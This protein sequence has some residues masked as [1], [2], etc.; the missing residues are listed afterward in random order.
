MLLAYRKAKYTVFR[1]RSLHQTADFA[2]YELSLSKRLKQLQ[3]ALLGGGDSLFAKLPEGLGTSFQVPKQDAWRSESTGSGRK[4]RVM[5][6]PSVD[7]HVI[8]ALWI[9]TVGHRLDALLSK[10]ALGARLRRDAASKQFVLGSPMVFRSYVHQYRKWRNQ[11]TS[12]LEEQAL[13]EQS[14]ALISLDLADYYRT[15]PASRVTSVEY[16]N[17][18]LASEQ[19]APLSQHEDY[20]TQ[21]LSAAI[22][23]WHAAQPALAKMPAGLPIGLA[24]SRVLGNIVLHDFDR[25]TTSALAPLY[26]SRYI[27]DLLFVLRCSQSDTQE[28]ALNTLVERH[29]HLS[30]SVQHGMVLTCPSIPHNFAV[31]KLKRSI[32]VVREKGDVYHVRNLAATLRQLS[33]ESRLLPDDTPTESTAASRALRSPWDSGADGER[34]ISGDSSTGYRLGFASLLRQAFLRSRDLRPGDWREE[35]EAFFH[36]IRRGLSG[37]EQL[38]TLYDYLP[39]VVA[40]AAAC[41]EWTHARRLVAEALRRVRAKSE[42]EAYRSVEWKSFLSYLARA[43]GDVVVTLPRTDDQ[44]LGLLDHVSRESGVDLSEFSAD[45][46]RV[47]S[48]C[49]AYDLAWIPLKAEILS[50]DFSALAVSG[51]GAVALGKDSGITAWLEAIRKIL[52]RLGLDARLAPQ[53]WLATRPLR[54]VEILERL[55]M[56][57]DL[58]LSGAY[59]LALAASEALWGAEAALAPPSLVKGAEGRPNV[60]VIGEADDA[61]PVVT[62]GV[63]NVL[64][65]VDHWEAAACGAPREDAERY[66][67]LMRL[68]NAFLVARPRP[69]LVVFPELSIPRC[70]VDTIAEA[71]TREGISA[72]LGLEYFSASDGSGGRAV[73]NEAWLYLVGPTPRRS[74]TM[75]KQGK[76]RPALHEGLELK[77]VAGATLR[78]GALPRPIYELNGFRFGLLICSELT[79]ISARSAF[80][81]EVDALLVVSWNR[82]L[83][84]FESIVDATCNDLHSYLVLANNRRYGDSRIRGP[85]RQEWARDVLRVRGGNEDFAICG[86]LHVDRLRREQSYVHVADDSFFKPTPDGFKVSPERRVVPGTKQKDRD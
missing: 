2:R 19:A 4:F 40:L 24:A 21:V 45:L 41:H 11:A 14:A 59:E 22:A 67:R 8:S 55:S 6:F 68:V 66:H 17:A 1:E 64:T 81:G 80:R 84:L 71:L 30:T 25:V 15:V 48:A 28:D 63:A 12:V 82:D 73:V 57:P 38:G 36:T 9:N 20:L 74:V 29:P 54:P 85:M 43:L 65:E 39:R 10:S 7:F 61:R 60:A 47:A 49:R 72:V 77:R 18:L 5:A 53:L 52:R 35:R 46:A 32:H 16:L 58:D 76:V 44:G 69:D 42:T 75:I 3:A 34:L 70:W 26:Y 50:E 86:G 31:N 78:P 62:I 56:S 79:D 27:D 37:E 13:Q 83:H 33:S 23:H 51:N